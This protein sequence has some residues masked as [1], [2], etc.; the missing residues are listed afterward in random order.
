MYR[1][2][3]HVVLCPFDL[4]RIDRWSRPVIFDGE[5]FPVQFTELPSYLEYARPANNEMH[6]GS[7]RVRSIRLNHPGGANGFRIDDEDGAS[8]CYLTDNELHP[9][10]MVTSSPA[11]LARFAQGTSLLIHDAQ[12]LCSDLPQKK[13]WGHSLVREVL[14]LGRDAEA[15]VVALYHHDPERDDDALDGIGA[16]AVRWAATHAPGMGT[17]VAR[18]GL[19]L[20]V[21]PR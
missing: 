4:R 21:R 6:I 12:Y 11:D 5:H 10:G 14:E 20:E 8:L 2:E 1:K 3:T 16:D 7:G 15:D 9:P 18:E 17:I 19:V 13:G